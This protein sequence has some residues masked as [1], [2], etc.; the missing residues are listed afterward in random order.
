MR[1]TG[2]SCVSTARDDA[3]APR[4]ATAASIA[5]GD[6]PDGP[7]AT[8]PATNM[9]GRE[10]TLVWCHT[11]GLPARLGGRVAGGGIVTEVLVNDEAVDNPVSSRCRSTPSRRSSR[12]PRGERGKAGP[13]PGARPE[14]GSVTEVAVNEE[15]VAPPAG[16]PLQIHVASKEEPASAR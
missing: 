15:A 11:V 6:G 1:F 5:V 16:K 2:A 14:Q 12:P 13:C 3:I 7:V 9:G 8:I 10:R 4:W